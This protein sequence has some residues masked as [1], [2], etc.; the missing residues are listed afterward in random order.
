MNKKYLLRFQKKIELDMLEGCWMWT[1]TKD[2]D[3]YG[4]FWYE[5]KLVKAHRISYEH[6]NGKIINNYVM[7]HVCRNRLCVNPQHLEPVTIQ[8]NIKRGYVGHG[9]H[10]KGDNHWKRKKMLDKSKNG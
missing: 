1:S 6:W 2:M 3:G 10:A 5:G 8:E 4:V 9:N 7:D